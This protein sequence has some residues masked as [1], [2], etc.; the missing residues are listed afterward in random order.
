MRNIISL[1]LLLFSFASSVH[2]MELVERSA[3]QSANNLKLYTNHKDLYVEDE[4]AAYRIE[5]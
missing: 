4:N 3:V 1:S 5:R 2:S